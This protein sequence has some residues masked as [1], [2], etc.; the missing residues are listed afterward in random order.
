MTSSSQ[1]SQE[2]PGENLK[3]SNSWTY[4]IDMGV[5]TQPYQPMHQSSGQRPQYPGEQTIRN[6]KY[7]GCKW[8]GNCHGDCFGN[9]GEWPGKV[10]SG[11]DAGGSQLTAGFALRLKVC[12]SRGKPRQVTHCQGCTSQGDSSRGC[13]DKARCS[14]CTKQCASDHQ[15]PDIVVH[16]L[17]SSG[18]RALHP[19]LHGMHQIHVII[20]EMS[21]RVIGDV[22]TAYGASSAPR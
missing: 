15:G 19:G 2:M 7:E 5:R 22:H 6:E 11:K 8:N 3:I 21:S 13:Q 12:H 1:E 14:S 9:Q 17:I 18:L 20:S 10:C 4:S 16:A